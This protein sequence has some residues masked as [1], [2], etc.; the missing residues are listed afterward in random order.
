MP[1]FSRPLDSSSG[2][3]ALHRS[4]LLLGLT[5]CVVAIAPVPSG[6]QG[7]GPQSFELEPAHAF[8]QRTYY[9]VSRVDM[10]L[11]PS[12]ECGGVF[13]ERLNRRWAKCADGS[14]KKECQAAVVDLSALGLGPEQEAQLE[15]DFFARRVLLR[16]RLESVDLGIGAAVP[17]L[18]ATD[19]WRGVSGSEGRYGRYFG[20]RSSGVV[21]ITYPCPTFNAF[22]LNRPRMGQLHRLDLEPSG[23]T[24]EE[25]TQGFQAVFSGP[26]LIGFGLRYSVFGPAGRGNALYA[27]EFYTKVESGAPQACGGFTFPPNP[28]CS[29]DEFCEQPAG[30]CLIADL[31]G[32][33]QSVPEVCTEIYDPVCGCDG[34]TY[35]NDC[36]RQQA[37]MALDHVGA[38]EISFD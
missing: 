3:A 1:S 35:A 32:T 14:R 38:C 36:F 26:G 37:Q 8:P 12:P 6:A 25:I 24:P 22:Q 34:R 13:V 27:T 30:S 17:T 9:R 10:R 7:A 20:V 5:L 28:S 21:C 11:C 18:V 23:A 2:L 4:L 16:G 19:A 33:C 31:P 15:L 29:A